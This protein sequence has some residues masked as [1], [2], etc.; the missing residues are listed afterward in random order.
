MM[1]GHMVFD[2]ETN[3]RSLVDHAIIVAGGEITKAAKN[4]IGEHL[5]ASHRS[6]ILF[7]DRDDILDLYVVHNLP[8]PDAAQPKQGPFDTDEM[9]F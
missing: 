3:R 1:L 9:P 7:M 4:W 5:D 8:L 2:P 6:Q